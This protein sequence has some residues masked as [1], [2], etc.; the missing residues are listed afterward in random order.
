MQGSTE[1]QCSELAV[2]LQPLLAGVDAVRLQPL[3]GDAGQ[4]RYFA[5]PD[6]PHL[7]A[8]LS[9]PSSEPNRAFVDLSRL[10]TSHQQP[11]PK[12]FA[13]NFSGGF[14]LLEHLGSRPLL[15]DYPQRGEQALQQGL[16]LLPALAAI[17][18]E[19]MA[20]LKRFDGTLL[21]AEM[22]LFEE[23]FIGPL[24]GLPLSA[25]EQAQLTELFALLVN[26]ALAQPQGFVHRDF[27]CRNLMLSASGEIGMIDY[28][29]AVVGPLSY[30]LVSLLKDCYWQW[31][32]KT[33]EAAVADYYRTVVAALPAPP[34]AAEFHRSFDW[35]G[36]QRHIKVLGIFARLALRD[37]KS[38][39]LQD[40]PLVI[41]YTLQTA[42]HYD[43]LRP[44]AQWFEA[45]LMPVIKRQA[46]H[47][48]AAGQHR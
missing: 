2:W 6:Y 46:W 21:T 35:M 19:S 33:V 30:D 3:P 45:R 41:T 22:A 20:G 43:E 13:V 9:P 37:G 38:Q 11:V 27:H 5:L 39:Y 36:L 24:L 16:A 48:A 4:R 1:Q 8:V 14:M 40:L 17:A 44:F 12:L 31:P 18:P 23:W 42:A 25:D 29:D 34:T 32:V 15:A 7:L 47:A 26:S 10:L 28:Q